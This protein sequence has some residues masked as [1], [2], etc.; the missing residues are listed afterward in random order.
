MEGL[1]NSI[2]QNLQGVVSKEMIVFIISMM[3]V[4]ELR[5]GLLAASI[6]NV[7]YIKA[8]IICVVGNLLPIPFVLFFIEKIV[9]LGTGFICR[10]TVARNGSMDRFACSR[11]PAYEEKESDSCNTYRSSYGLSDHVY[12]FIRYTRKYHTIKVFERMIQEKHP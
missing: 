4:L 3:P 1:V 7:P 8:L 11:T 9:I 2:T 5:G 6:L 12:C 10:D